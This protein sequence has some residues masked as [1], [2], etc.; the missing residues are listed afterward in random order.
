[1]LFIFELQLESLLGDMKSI[2]GSAKVCGKP[3]ENPDKCYQQGLSSCYFCVW[4]LNI[5]IK[6][7]IVLFITRLA[8]YHKKYVENHEKYIIIKH[9][10]TNKPKYK[11]A[12]TESSKST[13]V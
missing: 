9:M 6:Y 8:I 7:F 3:K 2:Y 12:K 4:K 5:F 1:M 11:G 10:Q 13:F